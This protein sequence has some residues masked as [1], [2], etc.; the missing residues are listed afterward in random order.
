MT[1]AQSW[2]LIAMIALI[3]EWLPILFPHA[4]R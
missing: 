4:C 3:G 2:F 1:A